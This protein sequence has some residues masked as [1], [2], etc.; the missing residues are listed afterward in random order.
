MQLPFIRFFRRSEPTSERGRT[1][2]LSL[3]F[4]TAQKV[5]VLKPSTFGTPLQSQSPTGE[6]TVYLILSDIQVVWQDC[7]NHANRYS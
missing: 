5:L 2:P 3:S 4:P 7:S 1:L 6:F